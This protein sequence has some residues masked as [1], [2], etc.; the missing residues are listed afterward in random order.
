MMRTGLLTQHLR[1][2]YRGITDDV[3]H[4]EPLTGGP[5]GALLALKPYG[6]TS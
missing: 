1:A 3:Y 2:W 4:S 5:I 6:G